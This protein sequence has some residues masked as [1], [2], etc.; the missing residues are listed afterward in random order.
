MQI[1]LS[2]HTDMSPRD[3]VEAQA[4]ALFLRIEDAEKRY[5]DSAAQLS[6]DKKDIDDMRARLVIL[7]DW[8]NTNGP[9]KAK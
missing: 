1:H 9:D 4:N 5:V 2:T 6:Q 7:G 3:I 8:L